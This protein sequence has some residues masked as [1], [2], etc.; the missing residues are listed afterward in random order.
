[1]ETLKNNASG[2]YSE[3][4]IED[5]FFILKFNN[6][7][8]ENQ[9]IAREV[10]SS[11]IQFHFCAKGNSVFQFNEGNYKLP[12]AEEHSLLLY[13]PQRDL[14]INLEIAP[15]SWV[16]SVFISIKK[17]HSLFSREAD[18][19]TFLSDENRDRKYYKDGSISPSM[20]IV[21]NQLINY[22]LHPSVKALYFK[23]KAYELLSLYFNRPSEADTEQCPFLV[24]EDNVAKIKRAKDIVINRMA[25]PPSLQELAD[26]I[27][28][29]LNKLKEGFKQ[30][31][32]DS[33]YSFLFDYKMEVARQ[34]LAS[35][36][37]NVNE[38]GLKIGYSTASHFIAAF[39][40]QYGTT[41]KKYVQSLN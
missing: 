11:Y 17:F 9:L 32:G 26:E 39:K 38:V 5:G 20:A 41:P 13:N 40:K 21:L 12:L 25:E 18:F 4:H 29:S 36:S 22:N 16:I 27:N 7:S 19:I 37:H 3:T 33:V 35:G 14:P 10:D 30:I 23:G 34:L 24:D 2:L 31:Y 28:L 8:A 6:E 1:M 15:D